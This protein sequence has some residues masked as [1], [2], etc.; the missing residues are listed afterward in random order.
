MASLGHDSAAP[1]RYSESWQRRGSARLAAR[2]LALRVPI[3]VWIAIIVAGSTSLRIVSGMQ[4]AAPWIFPDELIYSEL[5]KSF[6]ATGHFAVRGEPFSALSFGPLYP[7]LLA[8]I[9]RFAASDAQAY[10]LIKALNAILMSLAAVPTYLIARRLLPTR[11]ALAASAVAVLIPA[12]VYSTKVMTESLAYPVFLVAIY[13]FIR[14]V[15]TRSPRFYVGAAV[16]AGVAVLAR[17]QMLVLL[18]ALLTATIAVSTTGAKRPAAHPRA[19]VPRAAFLVAAIGTFI[20]VA[21]LL[22]AGQTRHVLLG[23]HTAL[24]RRLDLAASPQRLVYHVAELDLVV[25]ALPL[26]AFVVMAILAFRIRETRCEV[27]AFA[28]V[29]ASVTI[30]LLALVAIYASQLKTASVIY[31]RYLFYVV[32]LVV[33]GFLVWLHQGAPRPRKL[34]LGTALPLALLPAALPFHSLISDHVWGVNSA[35]PGLVPFA[36]LA[37]LIGE[38]AGI[39]VVAVVLS[40][41]GALAFAQARPGR[42]HVLMLIVALTLL[43]PRMTVDAANI[44]IARNAQRTGL[45]SAPAGWVDA[46]VGARADVVAVWVGADAAARESAY[47]LWQTE[48]ANASIGRVYRLREPTSAQLPESPAAFRGA[49]LLANGFPVRAQYVLID[50]KNR[51]AGQR[52]SGSKSLVLY[53]VDGPVRRG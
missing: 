6:A 19:R 37:R 11:L 47:A 43:V 42:N 39:T 33:I 1:R 45:G 34:V 31:E 46:A 25:G 21:A 24:T 8:P 28:A 50:R 51:I 17:A 5:G 4:T 14:A 18:P 9:Y 35:T 36:L 3:W 30:W 52:V 23:Q 41:L 12:T 13:V 38:G 7:M 10:A 16:A 40:T 32:P 27:V 44:R 29:S 49:L 26:A 48:F 20:A 15:E 53:R 2:T 22:A